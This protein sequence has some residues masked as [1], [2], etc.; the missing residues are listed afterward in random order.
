MGLTLSVNWCLAHN[1]LLKS[2]K[3][4]H[5]FQLYI[6]FLFFSHVITGSNYLMTWPYHSQQIRNL[7]YLL[8]CFPWERGVWLAVDGPLVFVFL[9]LCVM[10]L[11]STVSIFLIVCVFKSINWSNQIHQT[12]EKGEVTP[13]DPKTLVVTVSLQ[14]SNQTCTSAVNTAHLVGHL[15][16]ALMKETWISRRDESYFWNPQLKYVRFW[17]ILSCLSSH[18]IH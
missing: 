13:Q 2:N 1:S 5:Y 16:A 14:C 10:T 3:R 7:N 11:T 18:L 9:L 12:Y 15:Y 6:Y 8:S 4:L 17:K